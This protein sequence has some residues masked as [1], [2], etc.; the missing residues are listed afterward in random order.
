MKT[1]I[2]F[3]SFFCSATLCFAQKELIS[4]EDMKFLVE[5][6][7]GKADT[8]LM[9]KGYLLTSANKKN[10]TRKFTASFKGG[11]K[12]NVEMRADGKR[13]Y[14]E[15]ATNEL[16]QYNII[17]NSIAQFLLKDSM[18]SDVQTY[19]VKDLGSIY[20]TINDTVPYS[21]IRKDYDIHLVAEK[22]K[23]SYN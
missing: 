17:Q 11:T 18:V 15:I 10:N 19:N 9:A 23:T 4:Y 6:N 8:F 20:I 16:S 12:S 5:N 14:V 7:L 21:P 13:I 1:L 2:L 22:N 3:V